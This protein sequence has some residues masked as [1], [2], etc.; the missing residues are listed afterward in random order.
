MQ[1][2]YVGDIGD[3]GKIALLNELHNQGMEVE[4]MTFYTMHNVSKDDYNKG[5]T[6]IDFM[7]LNLKS[8]EIAL[9]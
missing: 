9:S 4:I 7:K 2:R 8:L 1:D 6:Y 3:Y 5:M